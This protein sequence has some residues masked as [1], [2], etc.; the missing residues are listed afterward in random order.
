MCARFAIV[1][2]ALLSGCSSRAA[3]VYPLPIAEAYR[4]LT[5]GDMNDFR[6]ARQCG[7]L[8]HFQREAV[9]DRRVRWRVTSSGLTVA[10]F[11]AVLAPVDAAS[12]R[13]TIEI[14]RDPKGGE[15]YDGDKFY[16]RPALHQPLRPSVREL[17]DAR[18]EGRPFDVS[19]VQNSGN[20]SVCN[21]QRARL[22]VEGKAFSVNDPIGSAG[23]DS[24]EEEE[25]AFGEPADS[26][27]GR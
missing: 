4:K 27:S 25:P 18:I 2:A 8:I 3:D 9:P 15:I 1:A 13:I 26:G 21:V 24:A 23:S 10:S 11:T 17:I 20:D 19:H 22:E 16:P 7:V 5:T 14:P 6:V 12:T